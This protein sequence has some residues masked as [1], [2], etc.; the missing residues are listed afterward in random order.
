MEQTLSMT[1]PATSGLVVGFVAGG[2]APSGDTRITEAADTRVTE[3]G[4]TRITE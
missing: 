3:S 4:D 2:V 1:L